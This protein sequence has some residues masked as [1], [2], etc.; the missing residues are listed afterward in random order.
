M[1]YTFQW[2]P[3]WQSLP[4]MLEGAAVTLEVALL[5][6]VFGF[7]IALA[8]ALARLGSNRVAGTIAATWVEIAR[9]TPAI[10][11]IYMVFFGLGSFGLQF[12]SY[13]AVLIAITFNNAGYLCEILRGGFSGVP[14]TQAS[15]ALSLGMTPFQVQRYIVIPQVLRAVYFPITNQIVWAVLTTSLGMVVGLHELS[16]VTQVEQSRTFRT[17]EYFFVAGCMYYLIAKAIL[18]IARL[19]GWRHLRER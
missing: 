4:A 2:R 9:N 8:L 15:S 13:S 12:S 10:F 6:M 17:F 5:S 16:G 19:V 11:Q 18:L 7:V 3:V 14:R 1:N